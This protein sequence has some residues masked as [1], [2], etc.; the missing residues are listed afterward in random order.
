VLEIALLAR[1]TTGRQW[2]DGV[3]VN[4]GDQRLVRCV[5]AAWATVDIVPSEITAPRATNA[6]KI[7]SRTREFRWRVAML[8][9]WFI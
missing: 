8:S 6:A 4:V 5:D 7:A 2:F 1:A 3:A 9:R